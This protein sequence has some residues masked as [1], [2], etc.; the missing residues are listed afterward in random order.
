VSDEERKK[1]EEQ[2]KM[3]DDFESVQKI[4]KDESD[5]ES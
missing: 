5:K 2:K 1:A 3:D 4:M